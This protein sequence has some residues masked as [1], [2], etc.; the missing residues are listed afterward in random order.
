MDNLGILRKS[1]ARVYPDNLEKGLKT[2]RNLIK[3]AMDLEEILS[4]EIA[5][6]YKYQADF[7]KAEKNREIIDKFNEG[8]K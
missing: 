3:G 2:L 4:T 7:L 8:R 1:R 5:H 6:Y